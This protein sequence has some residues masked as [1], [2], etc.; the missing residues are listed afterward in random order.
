VIRDGVLPGSSKDVITTEQ[1]EEMIESG[2]E[3]A[4]E[5]TD[6]TSSE[7]TQSEEEPE[8]ETEE[9]WEDQ[10][11]GEE[12]QTEDT[13]SYRDK[14]DSYLNLLEEYGYDLP[15]TL[16]C[17]QAQYADLTAEYILGR[18]FQAV[19]VLDQDTFPTI[20]EK[21][22]RLWVIDSGIYTQQVRDLETQIQTAIQK[23][24]SIAITINEI[25]KIS[26]DATYDLSISR[27]GSLLNTLK[28]LEEQGEINIVTY[29]EFCQYGEEQEQAY[30]ELVNSYS[31]FRQEMEEQLDDLDRQE[32]EIVASLQ[33]TEAA[34]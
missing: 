12:P 10:A 14:A 15:Q 33:I 34:E 22:D 11:E 1:F 3:Y 27:F 24:Q 21:E 13:R 5:L 29:S 4:L 20:G 23:Q 18:G 16:L 6:D 9:A 19:C 8:T 25:L 32:Q 28:N 2:W 31:M 17:T 26:Q 30:K 7:E